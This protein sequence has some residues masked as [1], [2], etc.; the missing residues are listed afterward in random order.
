MAAELARTGALAAGPN[1]RVDLS[2]ATWAVKAF[3]RIDTLLWAEGDGIG[4]TGVYAL[5]EA[6]RHRFGEFPSIVG[7]D[8][9][10]RRQF[11]EN[12]RI[13]VPGALSVVTPPSH[14]WGL[15]RIKTRSHLGNY[16]LARRHPEL[17][18]GRRHGHGL[19]K[20]ASD[21]RQWLAISVYVL[22][23]SLARARARWQLS[24]GSSLVWER[25]ESSR[26]PSSI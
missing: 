22:V 13:G 23:K 18:A 16:E 4:R 8:A 15:V 3:Y 6:G 19:L 21:P 10:V 11:S 25:D 2:R 17:S 7:D 20:L 14:F 26:F 9:F 12:E 5:S 1:L 24:R